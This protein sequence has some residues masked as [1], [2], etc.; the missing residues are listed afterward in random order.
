MAN[1]YVFFLENCEKENHN[2]S[3]WQLRYSVLF[4][5]NKKTKMA[6]PSRRRETN[7]LTIILQS[8][9]FLF[10]LTGVV[11]GNSSQ[12]LTLHNSYKTNRLTLDIVSSKFFHFA[13]VWLLKSSD[14][15]S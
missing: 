11:W 12:N 6:A 2:P 5:S 15:S 4:K 14:L 10:S 9:G 3:T 1:C 7:A 8:T 13:P